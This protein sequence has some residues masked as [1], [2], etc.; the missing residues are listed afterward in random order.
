[1]ISFLGTLNENISILNNY[2]KTN[3][4]GL[5]MLCTVRA[6]KNAIKDS[7]DIAHNALVHCKLQEKNAIMHD[8]CLYQRHSTFFF[9]AILDGISFYSYGIT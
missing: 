9:I 7:Y 4:Q 2:R 1:M 6:K 5:L 8:A 3:V